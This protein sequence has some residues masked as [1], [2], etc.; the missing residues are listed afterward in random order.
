M[1][2]GLFSPKYIFFNSCTC[3]T[4]KQ[5]ILRRSTLFSSL[6]KQLLFYFENVEFV[7]SALKQRL[8]HSYS[9]YKSQFVFHTKKINVWL[10]DFELKDFAYF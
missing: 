3:D 2:R 5:K 10:K 6:H 4:Q 7:L 8:R 9:T 1:D